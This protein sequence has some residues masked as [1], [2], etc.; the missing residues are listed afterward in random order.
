MVQTEF[1]E[2][3]FHGDRERADKVYRNFPPLQPADV[4]EA[5]VFCATR[6]PHVAVQETRA[7][8]AGPGRR[9]RFAPAGRAGLAAG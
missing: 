3:R 8:A 1:S 9:L 5:I 6:P 7:D 4:A 2:V